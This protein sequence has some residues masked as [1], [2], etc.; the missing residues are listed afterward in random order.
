MTQ[1][2]QP[3]D[4][5]NLLAAATRAGA[6]GPPPVHLWNPPWCG[7]IDIRIARDGTWFH[8]GSP[9]GREAMVK[10]FASILRIDDGRHVLVTPVEKVGIQV[11]DAPLLAVDF[12]VEG[13]GDARRITF[14]TNVGDEAELG[15][16]HPLRVVIDPVSQEPAIYVDIRRGLEARIDRKSYY[17]L[18]DLGEEAT[19]EGMAWFGLRA[20]GRFWPLLP[21]E[22]LAG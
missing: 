8:E 7:E 21:A 9:I 13:T 18:V 17:R 5:A 2:P 11:E 15:D 20:G 12:R 22:D 14:V 10:L 19:V 6:K 16:A 1:P 3:R 4:G